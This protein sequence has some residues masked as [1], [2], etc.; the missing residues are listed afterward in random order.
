MVVAPSIGLGGAVAPGAPTRPTLPGAPRPDTTEPP[1]GREPLPANVDSNAAV[2]ASYRV[3]YTEYLRAAGTSQLVALAV[4]GVAG[5]LALTGAGG[6]VG[7]RQAKAGHIVRTG[8]AARF[9]A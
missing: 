7:Y 2:P 6:F 5:I 4:P 3:G 1:A 9:V 8:G